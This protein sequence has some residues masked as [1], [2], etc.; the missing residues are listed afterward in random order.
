MTK[1]TAN[2]NKLNYAIIHT[3]PNN[4]I[5]ISY[6]ITMT[7]NWAWN[8]L[9][10]GTLYAAGSNAVGGSFLSASL[11]VVVTSLVVGW[12]SRACTVAKR[13]ILGL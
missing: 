1:Q 8:Y 3:Q 2:V 7:F 13:C 6:N 4:F 11:Y 12:L 5:N 9:Q 10:F